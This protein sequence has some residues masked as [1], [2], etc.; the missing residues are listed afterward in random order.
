VNGKQRITYVNEIMIR[1]CCDQAPFS[2]AGEMRGLDQWVMDVAAHEDEEL[3][4]KLLDYCTEIDCQ[5]LRL[6]AKSGAGMLDHGDSPAGPDLLSPRF[7]GT[8]ALPYEQRVA[9]Y[10]HQ[11]GLPYLV[12]IC[13]KT[14]RI[15]TQ[16]AEIGS[17]AVE[18]DYKTNIH[19]AHD[20]LKDKVTFFG[21]IDPSG[22]LA[23]GTPALV[24]QKTN[25][26]LDVF[27]DSPRFVLAAGCA[28]P[29][30][31]PS[32]NVRAMLACVRNHG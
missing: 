18:I 24:K 8:Y 23:L 3:V 32:E 21:N 25:E 9:A 6:M 5:S 17:D 28:L 10:A 12:H 27:A 19:L 1:V 26:L 20:V 15:L 31:T 2:L 13:G 11:Q 29:A 16:M 22:V 30:D 14:D 7:Y 4:H